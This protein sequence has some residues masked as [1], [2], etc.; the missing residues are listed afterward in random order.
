MIACYVAILLVLMAGW[1]L[2]SMTVLEPITTVASGWFIVIATMLLGIAA[3][4]TLAR[5]LLGRAIRRGR[6]V[7]VAISRR[8][9]RPAPTPS[10]PDRT[11][12]DHP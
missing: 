5:W 1:V 11:G 4:P 8:Y 10:P 2:L 7:S 3:A 9:A 12:R 6:A